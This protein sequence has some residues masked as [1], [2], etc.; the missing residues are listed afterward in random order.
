MFFKFRQLGSISR[1]RVKGNNREMDVTECSFINQRDAVV[2][3]QYTDVAPYILFTDLCQ[4]V[5]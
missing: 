4:V 3:C 1:A 5:F 2:S